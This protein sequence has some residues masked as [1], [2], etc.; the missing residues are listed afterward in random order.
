MKAAVLQN[1]GRENGA[2]WCL[3]GFILIFGRSGG[4]APLYFVEQLAYKVNRMSIVKVSTI[5]FGKILVT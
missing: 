2:F 5:Y 4:S 3:L 1:E